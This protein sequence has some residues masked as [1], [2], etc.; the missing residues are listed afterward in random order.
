M[1]TE[2]KCFIRISGTGF[3]KNAKL[4]LN[5]KEVEIL[6]RV[7]LNFDTKEWFQGGKH[8]NFS[9]ENGKFL[10]CAI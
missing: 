2:V 3:F 8:F 4:L 9:N 7:D 6:N 1:A 5:E 10:N